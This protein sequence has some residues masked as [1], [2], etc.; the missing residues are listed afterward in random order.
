VL[1]ENSEGTVRLG[2][3]VGKKVGNAVK[4][5][6]I[7]RLLREYFRLNR[8]AFRGSTDIV[9]IARKDISSL[10]YRDVSSELNEVLK[11]R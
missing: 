2:I 8:D 6:R 5:N 11:G 10:N 3:T 4:R 1:R 7:K 9:I